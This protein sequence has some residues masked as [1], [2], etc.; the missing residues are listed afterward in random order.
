MVAASIALLALP[1]LLLGGAWLVSE[2][3]QVVPG[4][5]GCRFVRAR[6]AQLDCYSRQFRKAVRRDGLQ[7]ALT[8]VDRKAQRSVTLGADCHLAWHPIGEAQGRRD[9][10]GKRSFRNIT[11]ASSCQQ[12]WAHGYTI[13]YLDAAPPTDAALVQII[14]ADCARQPDLNQILNCMHAFGH[15]IARRTPS[16]RRA[17]ARTCQQIDTSRFPGADRPS[18]LPGALSAVADGSLHQCLYGAYMEFG[19]IDLRAGSTREDNCGDA[20]SYEARKAC[21][22]YLS[23]RVGAIH[24]NLRAAARACHIHAPKGEMRDSCIKTFAFGLDRIARCSLLV[25]ADE[26]AACRAYY[27]SYEEHQ[28]APQSQQVGPIDPTGP[29]PA[30]PTRPEAQRPPKA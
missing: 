13:G 10:T 8:I 25:T 17:A 11:A 30:A 6:Q 28:T 9:A 4:I 22:A 3:H 29:A 23:G 26:Q 19:M 7:H 2:K 14:E 1:S 27:I 18:L 16:D 24:G 12:G 21:Y 5:D 20:I 15:T